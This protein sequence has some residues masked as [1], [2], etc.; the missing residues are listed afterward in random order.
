MAARTPVLDKTDLFGAL[1]PEL[2]EQL[3]DRAALGRFRRGDAIFEKGDPATQL[4]VCFSGRVAIIAKATDDRESVISVLGPGALFGE[5]SLFDGGV[6]SANAAALTT[7]HL[8][9]VDF[10]D[11][12]EVLAHRP[13]LLWTVVRILARRL[14][15]TDEALADAV[16]LDV[17]GRTAKRLLELADGEDEF[18]MPL[19]Q[20]ELAGMVGASRERVNK[21]IATFVQLGWLEVSGRG[22]YRILDR[23]ELEPRDRRDTSRCAMSELRHRPQ[24]MP[25]D[26]CC[27]AV[28]GVVGPVA[29]R[30]RGRART[31]A[32]RLR[33]RRSR[34]RRG[35][36]HA[37]RERVDV[38]RSACTGRSCRRSRASGT[39]RPRGRADRCGGPGRASLRACATCR[40]TRRRRRSG[41]R[42]GL[43]HVVP[44]HAE[45][46][47]PTRDDVV[48]DDEQVGGGAE[49][50]RA[51]T[52]SSSSRHVAACAPR[53]STGARR[54]TRERLDHAHREPVRREAAGHVLEQR[55]Q[56]HRCRDAARRPARGMPSGRAWT[57]ARRCRRR[58]ASAAR[59]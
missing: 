17:T 30:G 55:P 32:R 31:R 43:E 45:A 8:I 41:R 12:R 48:L 38:G 54:A 9:A 34:S 36:L 40:R 26:A 16:F 39:S 42:R 50:R 20:E 28:G 27:H 24:P 18:R 51:A 37:A 13:E 56:A 1:P 11:V 29:R 23:E 3:R 7:V 2:L 47:H 6:R 14:R 25:G 4:F 59:P 44:A 58:P 46:E 33:R 15:A 57:P 5:M 53:S 22:R 52:S 21:A 35:S 19:T 10:D 49:D